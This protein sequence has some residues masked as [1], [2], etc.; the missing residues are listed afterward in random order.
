MLANDM[1]HTLLPD[2]VTIAGVCVCVCVC[3]CVY[4]GIFARAPVRV[5]ML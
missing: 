5:P 4:L 1:V 3:V 2:A